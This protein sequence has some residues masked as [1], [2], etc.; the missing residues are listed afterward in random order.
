MYHVPFSSRVFF[1]I[2][3]AGDR[4]QLIRRRVF[5]LFVQSNALLF[6]GFKGQKKT[7]SILWFFLVRKCE[8]GELFAAAG[9]I[10]GKRRRQNKKMERKGN[11]LG[12]AYSFAIL[13]LIF[14]RGGGFE[15][16][17]RAPMV[18]SADRSRPGAGDT[19]CAGGKKN[20]KINGLE[21]R[22]KG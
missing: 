5:F 11:S 8:R 2:R 19:R 22:K 6:F 17:V 4:H 1:E 15:E 7:R 12:S 18:N 20:K 3:R 21:R 16:Q 14:S 13:F 9:R 10:K